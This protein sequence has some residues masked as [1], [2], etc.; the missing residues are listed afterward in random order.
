MLMM[1]TATDANAVRTLSLLFDFILQVAKDNAFKDAN[2]AIA[3]ANA[4]DLPRMP[5]Q[6][7]GWYYALAARDASCGEAVAE[8]ANAAPSFAIVFQFC[9][10]LLKNAKIAKELGTLK[11][12]HK[13]KDGR[14]CSC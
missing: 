7:Y 1:Q 14:C 13:A 11:D 3:S 2:A 8:N 12:A 5:R 10:R 6:P 4:T 9:Y